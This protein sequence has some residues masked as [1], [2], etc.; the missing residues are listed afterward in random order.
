VL[1]EGDDP[2]Q[3]TGYAA[4][5]LVGFRFLWGFMG[6]PAS[7]FRGFLT[8]H[9]PRA[10]FVYIL[11]WAAVLSLGA[12]GFLMGTDTYFGEEWLEE[13]HEALSKAV[14]A[15]VLLHLLGLLVHS[16]RRRRHAWLAMFSGDRIP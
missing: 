1:E 9:N 6:G 7:R 2:H 4:V 3:W 11:I 14:Q 13:L 15:L 8:Q 5:A 16:V 12:T 10:T